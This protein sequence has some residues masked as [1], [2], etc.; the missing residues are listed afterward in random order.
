MSFTNQSIDG[1]H[2]YVMRISDL[3]PETIAKA[4]AFAEE[5]ERKTVHTY[6]SHTKEER[7]E[8]IFYGKLGEEVFAQMMRDTYGLDLPIDY[9]IYEGCQSDEQDFIIEDIKIDVKISFMKENNKYSG[10]KTD[11][12]SKEQQIISAQQKWNFI[13]PDQQSLK[14]V[15]VYGLLSP[16]KDT[17]VLTSWTTRG[18]FEKYADNSEQDNRPIR[19]MPFKKGFDLK[20]FGIISRDLTLLESIHQYF[21]PEILEI[22]TKDSD[23]FYKIFV[24]Q[25]GSEEEHQRFQQFYQEIA[26][27]DPTLLPLEDHNLLQITN[28]DGRILDTPLKPSDDIEIEGRVGTDF[29]KQR[30]SGGDAR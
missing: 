14:D 6:P 19:K 25:T 11:T 17:I 13:L 3:P 4:K 9:R 5:T 20:N 24:S 21:S 18:I 22:K 23:T 1:R 28:Y 27:V 8:H 16:N 10:F 15:L 30:Y 26:D 12:K 7:I 2:P 29:Y